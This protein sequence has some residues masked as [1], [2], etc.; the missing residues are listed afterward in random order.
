LKT[1]WQGDVLLLF[2]PIA[3][4]SAGRFNSE[5]IPASQP[6]LWFQQLV[7]DWKGFPLQQGE[8]P[9][10][11]LYLLGE[12]INQPADFFISDDFARYIPTLNGRFLLL[13]YEKST[14]S[15]NAWTDRFGTLHLYYNGQALGTFSPSVAATAPKT[16]DWPALA[17][18]FGFGFFPQ[19]RT[20][21]AGL[22]ILRPATHAIF[23][24]QGKLLKK[25]KYWQWKYS[26]ELQ[27]SYQ[28]T[29]EEF[30]GIFS[31]VMKDALNGE[32]VAIPLSG[33]LDSRSSVAPL[34]N[35][36]S[37]MNRFWSYSYG[38]SADSI[39]IDIAKEIAHLRKLPFEN[40]VIKPYLFDELERLVAYTE[41]YQDLTQPRQ[42]YVR[43]QIAAH[44]DVL[45]GALWGDVWLDDMGLVE[46]ANPE[47]IELQTLKKMHKNG[48]AWLFDALVK[49]Q[50]QGEEP[51]NMLL[52][53][54]KSEMQALKNI[55]SP[56]FRVKVFKT[57]Q[58]SF[59]WSLSP[60]RIFQS[61]AWPR[62]IFYDTR[63]V[64][65]FC[66]VPTGF[67]TGRRLQIDYLKRF[68]PD[69][70]KIRWQVY[71]ANLYQ[72]Q[73]FNTWQVPKRAVKKALRALRG[74]KVLERNW[75]VQF[76]GETSRAKL[77]GFLIN[78]GL[79]IHEFLSPKLAM[80]LL[81][82]FYAASSA[83]RGYAVSMLL[84]FSAWLE[85]YG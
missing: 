25:E 32:R 45:I 44:S 70:A 50:L 30:G 85:K 79:R 17:G 59:R 26:P 20:H 68:A 31:A 65:F 28:E 61:A 4:P 46:S 6:R 8:T 15:W 73:Y 24:E 55:P 19:D 36:F 1:S 72:Y 56:D 42:M 54:V 75:E 23:D 48:R 53:F 13:A 3:K 74:E 33:G 67:L 38:Y 82:D 80:N 64:D 78:S 40:F 81:D 5:W 2:D 16:L 11:N 7:S 66:T 21:F 76:F 41:G 57:E 62:L 63:L 51:E 49:P 47:D 83:A 14:R 71:D 22:S 37:D 58:W 84:T 34:S 9:N 10:W 18:F 77:E 43:D 69:L 52:D 29:V 27:R 12:I 60:I 39:E 35:Q